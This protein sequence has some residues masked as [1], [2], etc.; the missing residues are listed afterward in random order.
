MATRKANARADLRRTA[1]DQL[2]RLCVA[3]CGSSTRTKTGSPTRGTPGVRTTLRRSGL[4]A[5]KQNTSQI[6]PKMI[7]ASTSVRKCAPKAIRLNPTKATSDTA[8][9]MESSR[10]WRA[11]SAGKT[12]TRPIHKRTIHEGPLPMNNNLHPL[13]QQHAA[14]NSDDQGHER[15]PP[16]FPRK[17]QHQRKQNNTDP[18][19][20]TKVSECA[21]HT[22]KCVRQVRVEPSRD[23]MIGSGKGV[24]HGEGHAILGENEGVCQKKN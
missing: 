9:K 12:V 10:Q 1:F 18:L 16:S 11:L 21:Q 8:L 24:D 2:R 3:C 7:A 15:G 13:V 5:I 23:F 14:G 20:R 17:K 4:P 6:I 22:D 19:G